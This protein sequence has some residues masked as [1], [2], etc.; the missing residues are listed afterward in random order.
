MSRLG[1]VRLLYRMARLPRER[2]LAVSAAAARTMTHAYAMEATNVAVLPNGID[3]SGIRQQ[4]APERPRDLPDTPALLAWIGRLHPVKGPQRMIRLMSRIVQQ[5]P[6]ARLVIIGDGPERQSCID[7]VRQL[8]LGHCVVLVGQ[9][10]DVQGILRHVQL[11]CITSLKEGFSLVAAEAA[12][13]GVPVVAYSVGGLPEVVVDGQTGVLVTDEDGPGF[14]AA[15][16]RV[17]GDDAERRR[18]SETAWR[19]AATFSIERHVEQLVAEYR[20]AA[21]TCDGAA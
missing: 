6:E 3:V 8:G 18:L 20:V 5:R 7:L 10:D 21:A 4:E 19:H 16:A 12:A 11:V 15:V 9:R 2:G 14:V 17:L 1:P 13:V